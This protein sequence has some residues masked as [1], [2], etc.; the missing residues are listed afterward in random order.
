MY[1]SAHVGLKQLINNEHLDLT[2]QKI[3]PQKIHRLKSSQTDCVHIKEPPIYSSTRD[4]GRSE[5]SEVGGGGG[6]GG[7]GDLT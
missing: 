1:E 2:C 6:G 4:Q 5:A 7:W 3:I